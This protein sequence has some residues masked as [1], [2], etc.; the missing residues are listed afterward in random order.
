MDEIQSG[1]QSWELFFLVDGKLVFTNQTAYSIS[2]FQADD[3]YSNNQLFFSLF[4]IREGEELNGIFKN[5]SATGK[6]V[7]MECTIQCST[8]ETKWIKLLILPVHVRERIVGTRVSVFDISKYIQENFTLSRVLESEKLI[9]A[10]AA[11][12]LSSNDYNNQ[13]N[14][15]LNII[16]RGLLS[17]RVFIALV[18][19]KGAYAT[20]EY[21]WEKQKN[22]GVELKHQNLDLHDFMEIHKTFFKAQN[23]FIISSG[24]DGAIA[25]QYFKDAFKM[26]TAL[27]YPLYFGTGIKGFFCIERYKKQH[28]FNHDEK[29]LCQTLSLLISKVLNKMELQKQWMESHDNFK[30][31]FEQSSEAI[32]VVNLKGRIVEVNQTACDLLEYKR[33]ELIGKTPV[34][35][36]NQEQGTKPEKIWKEITQSQQLLFGTELVSRTGKIIPIETKDRVIDF[37]NHK[38]ILVIARVSANRLTIERQIIQTMVE[39]EERERKRI[40]EDLHDN[41]APLL[42]AVKLLNQLVHSDKLTPAEKQQA[43]GEINSLIDDSVELSRQIANNINP[44]ILS[45]FGLCTSI[46]YFCKKINQTKRIEL[47]FDPG[48]Y[49]IICNQ[50][51]EKVLYS[52][53]SELVHNTL[54]HAGATKAHIILKNDEKFIYFIYTDN[55][56]GFDS[57]TQLASLKGGGLKNIVGK[58]KGIAGSCTFADNH[59]PGFCMDIIVPV[60]SNTLKI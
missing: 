49:K 37:F 5:M 13:I 4:G 3:F 47:S 39:T 8:K 11:S 53:V 9:S 22:T 6:T 27:L 55:G 2:G 56:K 34:E 31:L 25:F 50:L 46:N 18:G 17:D 7:E 58:V 10:F 28:I 57:Q 16:G 15:G 42:A 32:F 30:N 54:K 19:G 44:T 23:T 60:N 51:V 59:K 43:I 12:F 35:L 48:G 1:G 52:V 45:G 33:E 21:L 40:A 36:T 26:E 38:A 20:V 29:Q 14:N 24:G 41:L